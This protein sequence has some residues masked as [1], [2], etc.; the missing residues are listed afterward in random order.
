[1][2]VKRESTVQSNL[3]TTVTVG[4]EESGCCGEV[5]VLGRLDCTEVFLAYGGNFRCWPKPHRNR[6]PREKSLWHPRLM[7]ERSIEEVKTSPNSPIVQFATTRT[8]GKLRRETGSKFVYQ[9]S[10][11]LSKQSHSAIRH[12]ADCCEVM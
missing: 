11:Y 5:A 6:K 7:R 12:D 3:S 1:M 4:T 8:T 9:R 10:D 2:S